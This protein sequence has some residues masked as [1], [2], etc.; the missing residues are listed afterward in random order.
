MSETGGIAC[1]CPAVG[2]EIMEPFACVSWKIADERL[3]VKSPF[4]SPD[5]PADG[6]GF[7]MT[8]DRVER[9]G[10]GFAMLGRA[11]G[12]VKV[13]GK[14]V[15]LNDVRDTIRRIA[16]VRDAHVFSLPG[17]KARDNDVAAVVETDLPEDELKRSLAGMLESYAMPRRMRIVSTMPST[18]TGK[19]DREALIGLFNAAR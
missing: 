3:C 7:F 13:G 15:D 6:E 14:R 10:F 17:R 4:L 16:G 5:L 2:R 11:D 12:V 8:G 9:A 18:S 19:I 1:R